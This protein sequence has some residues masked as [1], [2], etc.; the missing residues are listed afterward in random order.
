M[1]KLLPLAIGIAALTVAGAASAA[2]LD[3]VKANDVLK[4]GVS[5]GLAGFA[6]PDDDGEW[7]GLDVDLC[8]AVA[9]AVLGDASKVE[10][11]P[12]TAK[13]RFEVLKSGEIDMLSRVTTWTLTRDT[14]LGLNFAGVNYYDGQG[15]MVSKE[16]G[17]TSATELDGASVCVQTGT[18]TEINLSEY[19]RLNNM[20]YE[21]VP[22]ETSTEGRAA[23][24]AGRCDIYTTDAS[25][26]AAMRTNLEDP[27]AHIILPEIISKEPL[28]PVVRHGDDQWLD[29]VKWSHNAML[30]AE[31]LG[32]TSANAKE[33][34]A[35]ASNPAVQKLLGT[36]GAGLGKHLGLSEDWAMNI[37]T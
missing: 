7:Q 26:L 11:V 29:I 28:G 4:C 25:A 27:T 8:R 5:T 24:A 2:T 36:A 23:Y 31:E 33:R 20:K 6:V 12:T 1:K 16:L 37:I 22:V 19:F 35:D 32:I 14:N 9:A 10:Y 18:T 15:F 34:S 13:V 3:E 21:P 30:N 17:A